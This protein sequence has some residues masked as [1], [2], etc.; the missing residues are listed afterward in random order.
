[1]TDFTR[2]IAESGGLIAY[3][4]DFVELVRQAAGYI[5]RKVAE[6]RANKVASAAAELAERR[7]GAKIDAIMKATGWQQHSVRG[8]LGR[9]GAQ[10]SF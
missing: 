9:S 4:T 2:L 3:G 10:A 7:G 1:M 8:F 5:D 6:K